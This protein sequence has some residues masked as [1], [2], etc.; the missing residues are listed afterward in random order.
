MSTQ[1]IFIKRGLNELRTHQKAGHKPDAGKTK[2]YGL[3]EIQRSSFSSKSINITLNR[4]VIVLG[5][6]YVASRAAEAS[7]K[8]IFRERAS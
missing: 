4:Q 8:D 6:Y 3:Q 5:E 7:Y 1:I 2:S